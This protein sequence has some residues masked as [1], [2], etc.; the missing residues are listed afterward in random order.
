MSRRPTIPDLAKA[1]G[2]SVATVDRVLNRRLAVREVTVERV[3]RAAEQI[4]FHAA[5][6][7]RHRLQESVPLRRFGFLLQGRGDPFYR[8]F[9]EELA[10]AVR[11]SA[12]WGAGCSGT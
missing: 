5:G 9:G 12:R 6:L 7:I 8:R 1:A 10:A 2:V 3:L 11:I 4:G